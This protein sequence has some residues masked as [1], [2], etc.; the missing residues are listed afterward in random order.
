MNT[1]SLD[2]PCGRAFVAT[3]LLSLP[4]HADP[5]SSAVLSDTPLGYYP[6]GISMPEDIAVNSGTA[7]AALNGTHSGVEHQYG[8]VLLSTPNKACRY[9][10]GALSVIPFSTVLNPPA[11]ESFTIEAWV[12]PEIDGEATAQAPL[13]NRKSS[14]DRQGWIFFQRDSSTGWN[15]RMYDETGGSQSID[16]TGGSY[17][18]GDWT[19]LA[20]VWNGSTSTATLYVNGL[21]VGSQTG[22]YVANSSAPF[23][24]GAYSSDNAGDNPFTGLIDEVGF[25]PSALTS[26]QINEHYEVGYNSF[27]GESYADLVSSS[28]PSL[29]LRL[30]EQPA[31]RSTATNLGSLG[32]DGNG[33][34]FTGAI[35][36][37]DGALASEDD[38][39][40]HFQAIDRVSGD[41]GYPTVLPNHPALNTED[42]SW[43]GWV[44]PTAEGLGNAQCLLMNYNSNGDRTGWVIWQRGSNAASNPGEGFGWNLRAYNGSANNATI[45]L[46]TGNG[47]GGYTIG[48]WQHL[49]VTYNQST[50]TAVFY[51]NGVAAATQT[52]TSGPY[53]PNPGTIIPAIGGFSNGSENPFQGDIDEVAFYDTVLT[54]ARVAE[55]Y[56]VGIDPTPTTP[57]ADVVG[58]DSPVAYYRMNELSHSEVPNLGSLGDAASAEQANAPAVIDGP[59][60]ADFAGFDP[61]K[62]ASLFNGS[63]THVELRNPDGLNFNGEIT[64]EAWVQPAADQANFSAN[65]IGHGANDGF[66]NELALRIE[67][68]KYEVV[69]KTGK[70]SFPVPAADL[71]TGAWVH[72]AGTWKDGQWSLYRNGSLAATGADATGPTMIENANWAIGARGRWK[73]AGGF[74]TS[75][76]AAEARIFNGGITDAAIYDSALSAE[77]IAAHYQAAVGMMELFIS[78]PGGVITLEWSSGILQESDTLGGWN[79]R[80]EATSPHTPADGDRHFYRLR[81]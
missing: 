35:H 62:S 39:A 51:V 2:R 9:T 75:P 53:F 13:Y 38:A 54:P 10:D 69:S 12:L 36:G 63:N 23:S 70:A 49:A 46:V 41:G 42:F 32:T 80:L 19:H 11:T 22:S 20:V 56:A 60:P 5:Y 61:E 31:W 33:V 30:D 21:N 43:E 52:T 25:Y 1:K 18:V 29:Y 6:L 78:R 28:N 57:Y 72:L 77:R 24:I 16:I 27:D 73:R 7:G 81:D 47:A 74:P 79:D 64:L 50:Q 76:N 58:S 14:G 40:I 45:N 8:G 66:A 48:E 17:T 59:R 34:H 4:L 3:L 44:R 55:H 15:F 65:I 68:G 67:D 37:V 26:G 71:G